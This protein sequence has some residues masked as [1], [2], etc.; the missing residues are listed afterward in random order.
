MTILLHLPRQHLS[1]P[2]RCKGYSGSRTNTRAIARICGG[3]E[4]HNT[5]RRPLTCTSR[6]VRHVRRTTELTLFALLHGC[7]ALVPC[8]YHMPRA[9]YEAE[10][11]AS[12][13][14]GVERCPVFK[15]ARVMYNSGVR[16]ISRRTWARSL[17]QYLLGQQFGHDFDGSHRICAAAALCARLF[18]LADLNH[19]TISN[20]KQSERTNV[21]SG[22]LLATRCLEVPGHRVVKFPLAW[23]TARRERRELCMPVGYPCTGR[24]QTAGPTGTVPVVGSYRSFHAATCMHAPKMREATLSC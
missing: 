5:C 13:D 24:T 10:R 11:R 15:P 14:A 7:N 17:L 6:S 18:P 3:Y 23:G 12:V 4:G 9:Q 8:Q 16:A 2:W 22:A 19:R 20:K 21:A 1:M